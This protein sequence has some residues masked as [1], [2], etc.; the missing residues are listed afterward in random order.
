VDILVGSNRDEGS[1][2]AG[3]GPPMR[4]QRWK[5]TA[6]QRWG[7]AVALGMKGQRRRCGRA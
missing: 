1:F 5:D 2:A 3:L 6:A 7:N 4:M